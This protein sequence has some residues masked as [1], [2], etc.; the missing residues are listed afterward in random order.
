MRR[1]YRLPLPDGRVLEPGA[2]TLVMGVLNVTPDSFSDGG[3]YFDPATAID[4]GA[5][6]ADAGADI[7]DVGGESTRPGA[8]PVTGDEERRR[9]LPVVARSRV[10]APSCRS[11]RQSRRSRLPPWMRA[12]RSINDVSGLL[13][14]PGIVEVAAASGA[15][16]LL[17][18]TRGRP[19]E[20]Y[21]GGAATAT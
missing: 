5:A 7:L 19:S 6:M 1:S 10:A 13:Y 15:A 8:S 2:R 11:T 21:D 3:L 9:V 18:H 20:M 16:L 4:A 17:V 14:D 12:R